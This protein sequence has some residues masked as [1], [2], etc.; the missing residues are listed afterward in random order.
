MKHRL[1]S[2]E[3]FAGALWGSGFT[4]L[5]SLLFNRSGDGQ[6]HGSQHIV[7]IFS[8]LCIGIGGGLYRI[9][10][11]RKRLNLDAPNKPDAP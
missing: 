2:D 6:I 4:L 7:L 9:V 11:H 3:F 5:I 1:F 8:S 10:Q